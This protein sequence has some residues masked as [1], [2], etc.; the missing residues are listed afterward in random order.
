MDFAQVIATLSHR[1]DSSKVRYALIGGFAKLPQLK[2]IHGQ[3]Q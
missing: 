2:S 3:A 1:L